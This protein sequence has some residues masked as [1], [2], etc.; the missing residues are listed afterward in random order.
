MLTVFMQSV[1]NGKC[2][3]ASVAAEMAVKAAKE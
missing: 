3:G 1:V 2:I